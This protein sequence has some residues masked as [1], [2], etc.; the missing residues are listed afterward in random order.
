VVDHYEN[1]GV[2]LKGRRNRRAPV[3]SV[4]YGDDDETSDKVNQLT[5]V[6]EDARSRLT[7]TCRPLLQFLV[8]EWVKEQDAGSGS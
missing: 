2:L 7:A 8:T 4:R 3:W 1:P 6:I 5:G